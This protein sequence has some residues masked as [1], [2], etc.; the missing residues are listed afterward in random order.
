MCN[1]VRVL[2]LAMV[3]SLMLILSGPTMSDEVVIT[4]GDRLTGDIVR[5][6]NETLRLKTSYTG[7]LE[8]KWS[9]IVEVILDDPTT[10]LLDDEKTLQV[11][12]FKRV[13]DEFVLLPNGSTK[14]ITVPASNVKVIE[15][16]PWELGQGHKFTGRINLSIDNERGNS[17]KNEFDLDFNLNNRWRKNN[18]LVFGQAEYDTTRGVTSTDNWSV[19]ANLDHTFSGNWYYAGAVMFKKDKFAD[20]QL[21]SM[22]GGGIGYR[23]YESKIKNLKFELGPYYLKDNFYSQPSVDFWGP[24]WFLDYDQKV[25]KQ[26][27]QIYHRQTGFVAADGGNKFLWR[28]WT[29]VRVPLISGIVGSAEY[30]IDYDSDPAV[31]TETTDQTFKLKLGYKW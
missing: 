23:F 2:N 7:T 14:P 28:S 16:E 18:L 22:Y 26:R 29:G 5:Q 12:S 24:A 25:W 3:C 10:I 17:E 31:D 21:R 30:E 15:P 4:N 11:D 13:E 27:L 9:D 8:I 6:D 19:M 20:L 1:D